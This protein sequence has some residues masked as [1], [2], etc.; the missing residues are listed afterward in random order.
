MVAAEWE[1]IA[2]DLRKKWLGPTDEQRRLAGL[3]ALDLDGDVPAPVVAALLRARLREALELPRAQEASDN[4]IKLLRTV[5]AETGIS[6]PAE[7]WERDL[8]DSWLEAMHAKR[9][10]EHLE[11]WSPARGDVVVTKKS[12]KERSHVISSI[13]ASGQL[14]F[15]GGRGQ[16]AWPHEVRRIIRI[17]DDEYA[18]AAYQARQEAAA[19]HSGPEFIGGPQLAALE[20]WKV[21]D[22]PSLAAQQALVAALEKADG[23]SRQRHERPMQVVLEQYPEILGH[24]VRGNHGTYVRQQVRVG[25]QYVA[26]FFV[27]SQTSLGMRWLLVELERPT[28]ELALRNG[29]E[30]SETLRKAIQQIKD[31]REWLANNLEQA[32]KSASKGGLELPGIR[33]RPPGL[34]IIGRE[35]WAAG[36]GVMRS[37][38]AETEDIQIRTYDWLVRA[39]QS[40]PPMRLGA[41]DMELGEDW[42]YD[43]PDPAF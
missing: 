9:A 21:E 34:I 19:R 26:D 33:T 13:G 5:A 7:V 39:A 16:R 10:Y 36:T 3:L 38:Y 28:A 25:T 17:S 8:L 20:K 6:F 12:G 11:R 35:D 27:G 43:M 1:T 40:R 24:L 32:Q 31:W 14:H 29:R 22:D 37:Q 30:P 18:K 41:L 23:G 15:R 42:G 4:E 2:I